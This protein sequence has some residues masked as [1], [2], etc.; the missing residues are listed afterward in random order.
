MMDLMF[1]SLPPNTNILFLFDGGDNDDS[2]RL[3]DDLNDDFET[4]NAYDTDIIIIT[5][6]NMMNIV[7]VDNISII[8]MIN[9]NNNDDDDGDDNDDN[10]D[11]NDDDDD[12]GDDANSDNSGDDD[13]DDDLSCRRL[14]Y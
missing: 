1:S 4:I 5:L 8:T 10:D 3:D 9:D 2:L 13:D 12:G 14:Q 7:D 6:K 11:S